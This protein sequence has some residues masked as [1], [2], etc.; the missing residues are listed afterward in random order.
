LNQIKEKLNQ[1]EAV[2]KRLQ[3][4]ENDIQN[5]KSSNRDLTRPEVQP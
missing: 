1:N 5:E 3:K 4:S 2:L